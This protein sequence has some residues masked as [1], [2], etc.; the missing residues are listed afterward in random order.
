MFKTARCRSSTGIFNEQV[1]NSQGV[2]MY[3]L[4]NSFFF[5]DLPKCEMRRIWNSSLW[6]HHPIFFDQIQLPHRFSLCSKPL[7]SSKGAEAD[8]LGRVN[9]AG[10]SYGNLLFFVRRLVP[11]SNRKWP[12]SSEIDFSSKINEFHVRDNY[13]SSHNHG[14]GKWPYCKGNK[15]WWNPFPTS[16]I[17]RGRIKSSLVRCFK[18]PF[19]NTTSRVK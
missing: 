8:A 12:F 13:P 19:S 11:S 3:N 17:M 4:P 10:I 7:S 5:C 1:E 6:I 16:M 14:S 2:S 9:G 18:S 15:S